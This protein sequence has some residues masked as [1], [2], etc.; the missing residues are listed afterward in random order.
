MDCVH[1]RNAPKHN[2]IA[3]EIPITTYIKKEHNNIEC[4]GDF[5]IVHNEYIIEAM[6]FG[7]MRK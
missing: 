3:N 2:P 5:A 1:T 6:W 7:T 4:N